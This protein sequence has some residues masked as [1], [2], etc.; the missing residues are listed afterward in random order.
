MINRAR[1]ISIVAFTIRVEDGT[2]FVIFFF[3]WGGI[4]W[5]GFLLGWL[6]SGIKHLAPQ[7]AILLIRCAGMTLYIDFKFFALLFDNLGL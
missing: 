2:F 3:Y 1:T 5:L 6:V 7:K 4:V